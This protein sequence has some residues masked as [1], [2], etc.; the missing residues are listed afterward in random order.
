M[1]RCLVTGHKG[2]IGTK[3]VEELE[4]QGHEVVGIDLQDGKDVILELQEHTDGGFHPHYVNF[5]PEYLFHLACIPRVAYSVE[6]PVETMQNNV[7]ATSVAL[8]FARKN[9][10]KRFVYSSSSSVRGNG[11]GPVSPYALQKY[12]SELEVGMYSALYG[13][14]D[15]VSLRYFN[16]YSHDQQA[17]GPYATAVAAYMR[18]VREGTTP[19][20]TGD[21]EQRRD[22]SHVLD[23]VSANIFAMEHTKDFS[24]QHFD[25]GTGSNISL[26]QIKNIVQKHHPSVEFEYVED[27][28]GDVRNTKANMVPLMELGW[29]PSWNINDGIEDC[30]ERTRVG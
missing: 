30:F 14:M 26:N 23:I 28:A 3:L 11:N 18:A 29:T 12:T 13:T 7:L 6:Q 2:Y 24:G 17:S 27:R 4:R 15:T 16:V 8:N 20:I 25:V 10:V 5:K 21:G 1:A 19:H 22:M 9:G